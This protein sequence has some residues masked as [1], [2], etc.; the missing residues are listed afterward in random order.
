MRK[1]FI[2]IW[3]LV[4]ALSIHAE[5]SLSPLDKDKFEE[6]PKK[7]VSYIEEK[8][9]EY[10]QAS[11]AFKARNL[12]ELSTI[13]EGLIFQ[14]ESLKNTLNTLT[15][16]PSITIPEIHGKPYK[17]QDYERLI[18]TYSLIVQKL[19]SIEDQIAFLEDD[20]NSL[21]KEEKDLMSLWLEKSKEEDPQKYVVLAQLVNVQ[22]KLIEGKA[23]LKQLTENQ[24]TYLKLKKRLDEK[25]EKVFS[26][27]LITPQD[28]KEARKELEKASKSLSQTEQ[29]VRNA[30]LN[31]N[32]ST[33]ILE[34]KIGN[35]LKKLKS[36][37]LKPQER[38][39]LLIQKEENEVLLEKLEIEK[40][41]LGEKLTKANLNY[42][43]NLFRVEWISCKAKL[44]R[45][46]KKQEYISRWNNLL[47]ELRD[48]LDKAKRELEKAENTSQIITGKIVNLQQQLEA[49]S[50]KAVNKRSI[51]SLIA[52]YK[53]TLD[54]IHELVY[55]LQQNKA[56]AKNIIIYVDK[57]VY[58]IRKSGNFLE[59]TLLWFNLNRK[60]IAAKIKGILYYPIGSLGQTPITL[61]NILKFLLIIIFGILT[62]KFVRKRIIN[63]LIEKFALPYGTVNS[64]ATIVY[65][66][67]IFVIL[68]AAISAIGISVKQITFIVGAL[69]VGIGF[70]LQT[71]INNFV[72]GLILLTERSIEIG[73][74][75]E[76]E[77]GVL[78]EVKK[79]NMRSTII[80][81][82]DGMDVIVPNSEL[83]S[84]KVTTWT[85]D[86]DWRRLKI[87]FG[88]AYG[89]DPDK[90]AEIAIEAAREVK[91]T[92]EDPQHQIEVWFE[93]FGDSS[94]NF[95]LVVWTK[96]HTPAPKTGRK[97]AYYFVLYRKLAEA[98]IE[99]PFPQRD[100]HIR[101]VSAD[102]VKKLKDS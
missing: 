90:V 14:L 41:L 55:Q 34:W 11:E 93:G 73:D 24:N 37:K 23:K 94:L 33:A 8:I 47:S 95:T 2:L 69:G 98:G 1:L 27:L 3:F 82:Y 46:K 20:V 16:T 5:V 78:G 6:S 71:I 72:S 101:S 67:S 26:H 102:V 85:Y 49:L 57:T 58:L 100:I 28:I 81:T 9:K 99:I 52:T 39:R 10:K 66:I 87:P 84:G 43:K 31:I 65:Y 88:V 32:K 35:I 13:F 80:R 19:E 74:I 30:K 56:F 50:P 21:K 76:L 15:E 4:V 45:V 68:A 59:K 25:L 17:L 83:I 44:C 53:S 51:Q 54:K 91:Y 60:S 97:S 86:D 92:F 70:G 38:K 7:A 96:M 12:T 77:S 40:V 79:I 29:S 36:P 75:V 42:E 62:A 22:I 61:A 89:T 18:K 48:Y 64:I 63:L